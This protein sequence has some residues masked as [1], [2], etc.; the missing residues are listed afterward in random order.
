M[1]TTE[2]LIVRNAQGKDVYKRRILTK[3]R[4]KKERPEGYQEEKERA[5]SERTL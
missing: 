1:P 4:V 3:E 5:I 2:Y